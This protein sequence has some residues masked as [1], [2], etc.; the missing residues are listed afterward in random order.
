MISLNLCLFWT[1][2]AV[3]LYTYVG[4]PVLTWLRSIVWRRPIAAARRTPSVSVLIAAHNEEASITKKVENVLA[5]NY[6]ADRL[7]IVV[8]S[9]GSSD[10]T[11]EL[12]HQFTDSRLKVL[13][14][15]RGGKAA[16][17]NAGAKHCTG[18]VLVF[19]DA[20]SMFEP[21][22]LLELVAPFA[23]ERVGGVAG[24]QRYA[25][26][27]SVS[28]ADSGER[29]YWDFDRRMKMWQSC[30]GNVTSATGAIYAIRRQ[31]FSSVPEGMTDDFATSTGVIEQGYRLVFAPMAAA[32]E[33]VAS[34]S[35]VEF[36]RKVRIIT[37]GLRGVLFR[38]RLLNPLRH[39]FY[40]WQLFSHKVLRRQM[41]FPL[42]L[43]FVSSV[44][45]TFSDSAQAGRPVYALAAFS[46]TLFYLAA[47][48]GWVLNS[49][50][51]GRLKPFSIPFYFCMVNWAC[52]VATIRSLKG[53]QVLLWETQRTPATATS[54][55]PSC[56]GDRQKSHSTNPE[57]IS[58]FA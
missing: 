34:S 31:L 5:L 46:Q 24:D 48:C 6:P 42:G 36:G 3:L 1:A 54:S 38:R 17:L 41:A 56:A 16:A 22:A 4:F 14:L 7:Q 27:K 33:P 10:R 2:I 18:E 51:A 39:G 15:P 28:A 57:Q 52:V 49:T 45:L 23:D 50:K 55:T 35:S 26:A 12:L 13:D 30:S 53:E 43:L 47:I 58:N 21:D 11:M 9:D 40:S 44:V 32:W 8:A 37:R 25:K 19:S 29:T 20:N